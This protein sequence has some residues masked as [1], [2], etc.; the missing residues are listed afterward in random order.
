MAEGDNPKDGDNY[1]QRVLNI[2]VH[3]SFRAEPE[4][5]IGPELNLEVGANNIN[6]P[7]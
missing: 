2:A 6:R 4:C 1:D 3:I 5:L 7:G